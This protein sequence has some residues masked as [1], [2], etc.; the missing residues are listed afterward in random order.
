MVDRTGSFGYQVK[1]GIRGLGKLNA[2]VLVLPGIVRLFGCFQLLLG[3]D[4]IRRR[5]NCYF[6]SG[7]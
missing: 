4:K 3:R 1:L 5:G 2:E 6:G 7:Y